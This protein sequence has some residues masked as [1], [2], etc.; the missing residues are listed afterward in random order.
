M[1]RPWFKYDPVDDESFF[2]S[3]PFRLQGKFEVARPAAEVWEEIAA[4]GTLWWCR[5]LD[6]IEWT[7]PRPFGVGTT[8]TARALHGLNVLHEKF[9]IWEEGRRM[10]FYVLEASAPLARRFAE[11]YVV[12]PISD[13]SCRFTWTIASEPRWPA[14][15]VLDPG[16]S[17]LLKTLFTD[18]ARHYGSA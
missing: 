10:S 18:T 1:Q 7:S 13:G 12:E 17:R 15:K 4:D 6:D 16:N 11:D 2:D 9:F 14:L 5:I 3:A 8:R